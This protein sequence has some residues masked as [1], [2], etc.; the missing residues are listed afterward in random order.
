M[1]ADEEFSETSGRPVSVEQTIFLVFLSTGLIERL[2][3]LRSR[4]PEA[5]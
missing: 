1:P 4:K 3:L 5:G 2:H